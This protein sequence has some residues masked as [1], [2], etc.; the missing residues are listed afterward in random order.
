MKK[1]KTYRLSEFRLKELEEIKKL[2]PESTET[3][4]IEEA[5]HTLYQKEQES[6]K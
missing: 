4:L 1:P 2:H 5:I 6:Q 3:E